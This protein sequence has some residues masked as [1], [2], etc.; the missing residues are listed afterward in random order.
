MRLHRVHMLAAVATTAALTA[1][2]PAYAYRLSADGGSGQPTPN[3][4]QD[5]PGGST[6][7]MLIGAGTAGGLALTGAG[8]AAGR[9]RR[10]PSTQAAHIA[11]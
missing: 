5:H 9:R 6:D 2:A 11:R 3:A 7:W 1:P 10:A 8:L 4:G